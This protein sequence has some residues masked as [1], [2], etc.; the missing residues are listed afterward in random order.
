[1]CTSP[2]SG[3][4][5]PPPYRIIYADP[6]WQFKTYSEK[7][8][9]KSPERHYHCMTLDQ[10]KALPVASIANDNCALF[11]WTTLP[12]IEHA[13]E[14]VRAWGFTYKTTAFVWVKPSKGSTGWH[15][16]CGY[17]TRANAELVLLG[18]RGHPKRV[19]GG[20]HQ[21]VSAPVGEHSAKPPEV[22]ERIIKL[23]GDI[24]RIELFARGA[25]PVGWNVW[26]NECKSDIIL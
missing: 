17:W 1:M 10:I 9:G 13:L 23:L 11:L 18:T 22:R 19:S 5:V 4:P 24:P 8:K 2:N 14:V 26:G 15:W 20:V 7:G 16:G 3:E 6:P 25:T 12:H 21:I